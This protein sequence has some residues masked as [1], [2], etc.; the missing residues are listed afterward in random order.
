MLEAVDKHL[1]R[2]ILGS[3]LIAAG[4]LAAAIQFTG[5]PSGG[6][7]APRV[8]LP[9]VAPGSVV[10]MSTPAMSAAAP[11]AHALSSGPASIS[12]PGAGPGNGGPGQPSMAAGTLVAPAAPAGQLEAR[13]SSAMHAPPRDASAVDA[14]ELAPGQVWECLEHGQK[15]FSDSRCGPGAAVRQL[16]EVNTMEATEVAPPSPYPLY[17]PGY[18][19]AAYPSPSP[20]APQMAPPPQDDEEDYGDAA[21]YFYPGQPFIPARNRPRREHRPHHDRLARQPAPNHGAPAPGNLR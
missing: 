10:P 4:T 1:V 8:P 18:G 7:S 17:R 3:A 11:D 5:Q 16:R 9:I 13:P 15:V 2:W 20:A 6:K 12:A 21:G 19:G 14:P